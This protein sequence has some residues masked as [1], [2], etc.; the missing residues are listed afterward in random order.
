MG[1]EMAEEPNLRAKV[2]VAMRAGS[3]G[4]G[5][6]WD[7]NSFPFFSGESD[8]SHGCSLLRRPELPRSQVS[9]M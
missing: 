5:P 4:A 9:A 2:S 8:L 3:A 1:A 6:V 7:L